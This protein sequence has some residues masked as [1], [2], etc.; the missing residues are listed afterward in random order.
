MVDIKRISAEHQTIFAYLWRHTVD[1]YVSENK[2]Y[3][4]SLKNR[5]FHF[6][7]SNTFYLKDDISLSILSQFD[8]SELL[9]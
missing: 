8:I 4:F 7:H 9:L 1:K 5:N 6:N 3:K 2:S